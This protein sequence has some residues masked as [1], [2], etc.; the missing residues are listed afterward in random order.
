MLCSKTHD[1]IAEWARTT[2]EC[3]G[4]EAVETREYF[5]GFKAFLDAF[6]N[7]PYSGRKREEWFNGFCELFGEVQENGGVE[8]LRKQDI[9]K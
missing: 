5:E 1:G 3:E 2:N 8:F 7:C 6:R 4:L 9:R